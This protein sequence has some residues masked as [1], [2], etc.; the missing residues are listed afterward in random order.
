MI[1]DLG[2]PKGIIQIQITPW[3]NPSTE[4]TSTTPRII[5]INYFHFPENL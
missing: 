2:S 1:T 5:Q 4:K 3:F